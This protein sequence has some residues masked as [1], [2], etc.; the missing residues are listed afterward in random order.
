MA[1]KNKTRKVN[2]RNLDGEVD[3]NVKTMSVEIIQLNKKIDK[4][5]TQIDDFFNILDGELETFNNQ[6]VL[7]KKVL[8][9][10]RLLY[11]TKMGIDR[12][13]LKMYDVD[14]MAI[15]EEIIRSM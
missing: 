5:K 11:A 7:K 13:K 14:A 10:Q 2:D 9:I 15:K 6:R 12:Q 4:F 8:A 1:I 3:N